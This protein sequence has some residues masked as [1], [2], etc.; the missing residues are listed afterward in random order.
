MSAISRINLE[1][2][3]QAQELGFEGLEE[4]QEA[5]CVVEWHE[6]SA[7][8]VEPLEA[9]HRAWEKEKADVLDDLNR[10]YLYFDK[11]TGISNW[12]QAKL[13]RAIKFIEESCD[14]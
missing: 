5:G 10:I 4:A 6:N 3:E 13:E 2:E 8:L 14:V 12:V 7:E 11:P 9:A 1:L